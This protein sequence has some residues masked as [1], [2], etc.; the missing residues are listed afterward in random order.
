MS[1]PTLVLKRAREDAGLKQT[2]MAER[3]SVS[4][5]V[6]SRL[7]RSEMTDET[8]ARR[9]LEAVATPASRDI[10]EF[11]GRG[12]RL[13]ERPTVLHPDREALWAGEQALQR[14][15]LFERSADYDALLAVPLSLIRTNIKVSTA[16]LGQTDHAM[17]W[18]GTVGI[19]KTTALSNL[20]NLMIPGKNGIPQPV[21]PAT[22]GR[23]TTSEVVIRIAPAYGIAVEPKTEDETRL[24]V[25][26]MVRAAAENKGGISTEL[27]RAIRNMADLKKQKNPEDIRNQIDPIS[28]MIKAA[29]GVQDDVVDEIV[30]RMRLGERTE[31]QLILSETN[32]DGLQWLS[33]NITA[34]NYGQ[35]PRFSIP[36][37]VTVFVPDSAVRRSPYELS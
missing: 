28:G 9:Y 4:G 16:F 25:S 36:Q 8:M 6:I 5:S 37:R 26:E 11:Y 33:K 24:L 14:L 1:I 21:F 32:E 19:G 2:A 18:I 30:N 15:E 20:T 12:W 10:L 13:S 31:T 3:L 34:I 27:D 17:A 23:T 22:G 7:E 29:D 35:D